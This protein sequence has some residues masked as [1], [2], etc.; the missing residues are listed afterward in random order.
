MLELELHKHV[1]PSELYPRIFLFFKKSFR[2]MKDYIPNKQIER[3]DF[4]ESF[5]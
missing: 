4:S 1:R 5:L 2:N 3:S